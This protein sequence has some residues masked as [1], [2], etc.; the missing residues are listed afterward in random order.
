MES[1]TPNDQWIP[2]NKENM[3]SKQVVPMPEPAGA[4]TPA[5]PPHRQNEAA[6]S[7]TTEPFPSYANPIDALKQTVYTWLCKQYELAAEASNSHDPGVAAAAALL[8]DG[9][10]VLDAATTAAWTASLTEWCKTAGDQLQAALR[11]SIFTQVSPA[12]WTLVWH[13]QPTLSMFLHGLG[14][15]LHGGAQK[16]QPALA[17]PTSHTTIEKTGSPS[18]ATVASAK[19][20]LTFTALTPLSRAQVSGAIH[21]VLR[22]FTGS[23]YVS[24]IPSTSRDA[25]APT[26][27]MTGVSTIPRTGSLRTRVHDQLVPLSAPTAPPPSRTSSLA[28]TY[29][30]RHPS[31][32]PPPPPLPPRRPD[33]PMVRSRDQDTSPSSHDTVHEFTWPA[34]YDELVQMGVVPRLL[35]TSPAPLPTKK[36]PT[37]PRVLPQED[38]HPTAPPVSSSFTPAP[39]TP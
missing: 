30:R 33:T 26:A 25:L 35:A 3:A 20:P 15:Y 9:A 14:V 21:Q 2:T 19:T 4:P 32:T 22:I 37:P 1:K 39:V 24:L 8:G 7:S 12:S 16:N 5:P 11:H 27:A 29:S 6:R 31:R 23:A 13:R 17:P 38:N 28:S 10:T 18:E 36:P 34:K